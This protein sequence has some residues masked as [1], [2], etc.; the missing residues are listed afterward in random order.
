M[1]S[2][3]PDPS[4]EACIKCHS[5]LR[6][7]SPKGDLQIPHKAHVNILKM[8]CV[9]CHDQHLVHVPGPGGKNVPTM[10]GCLE[11]CHDGETADNTCTD[12]HT[13]KAV[14]VTHRAA[15]WDVVHPDAAAKNVAECEKCHGWV[16]DWCVDCH[17]RRP[18][19]AHEGLARDAP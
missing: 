1:P 8:K 10:A 7:V 19:V 6:S 11:R 9:Q 13:Q 5:D 3:F 4:N 18:D 2:A 17:E 14:P 16:D 12:C 15:D